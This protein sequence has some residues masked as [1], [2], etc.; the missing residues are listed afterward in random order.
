MSHSSLRPQTSECQ[1]SSPL[2][3]GHPDRI[4]LAPPVEFLEHGTEGL[5]QLGQRVLHGDGTVI[6]HGPDDQPFVLEVGETLG[7]RLVRDGPD[8]VL[9][10]VEA[11]RPAIAQP[12]DDNRVPLPVE[13]LDRARQA[14]AIRVVVSDNG[15]A[16]ILPEASAGLHGLGFVNP[17]E[18]SY[19]A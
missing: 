6:F 5:S 7:Q 11:K 4:R 16:V 17:V 19:V 2:G 8:G 1:R 15:D 13:D 3:L 14:T 9:Q 12:R 10:F 18:N